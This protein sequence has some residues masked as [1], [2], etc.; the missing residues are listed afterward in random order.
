MENQTL[1]KEKS[2]KWRQPVSLKATDL[3]EAV[4]N[5]FDEMEK[6]SNENQ[7]EFLTNSGIKTSNLQSLRLFNSE[8]FTNLSKRSRKRIAK[9]IYKLSQKKTLIRMN[10][11]ISFISKITGLEPIKTLPSKSE[12]DIIILRN[13]YKKIKEEFYNSR[14]AFKNA[15][16][17]FKGRQYFA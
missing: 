10:R 4:L 3:K 17:E 8:V 1:V 5:T 12:Q 9:Q 14:N 7:L 15:K 6:F 11:F 16:K 13:N 2:P